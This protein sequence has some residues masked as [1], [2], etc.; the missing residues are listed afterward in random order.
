[1]MAFTKY[2]VGKTVLIIF[3]LHIIL[4]SSD[5][6]TDLI[7]VEKL[8]RG[9]TMCN[10]S[11]EPINR[12]KEEYRECLH[13]LQSHRNCSKERVSKGVCGVDPYTLQYFCNHISDWSPEYQ[14]YEQ[15]QYEVGYSSYC[16]DPAS[17]K[18]GVN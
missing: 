18:G 6:L 11:T 12:D 3:L 17:N 13:Q 14:D 9:I 15:C 10:Q 2:E 1:M 4:P 16:S 8:Y 7:L 5:I